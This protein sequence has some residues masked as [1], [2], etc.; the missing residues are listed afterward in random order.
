MDDVLQQVRKFSVS[1]AEGSR[2]PLENEEVLLLRV[3]KK[4][5]DLM[6]LDTDPER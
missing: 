6:C 5:P 4:I 1:A 3:I 2:Q